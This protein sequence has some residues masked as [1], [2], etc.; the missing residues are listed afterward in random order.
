MKKVIATPIP[1]INTACIIQHNAAAAAGANGIG[2][3]V[4][5]AAAA[6]A[7]GGFSR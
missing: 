3:A 4:A 5:A 2:V 7:A 6:A 1:K